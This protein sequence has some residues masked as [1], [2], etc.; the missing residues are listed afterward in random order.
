MYFDVTDAEC[1]DDY[2]VRL[3]FEDGSV[4]VADLSDYPNE[5]NVFARFLDNTYFRAFR[6]EYG[7]LVWGNGELDIAPEELYARA[8]GKPV[9]HG[10]ELNSHQG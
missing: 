8:T 2:R 1:L 10:A 3:W 5:G 7:A 4:G 9:R 6:V